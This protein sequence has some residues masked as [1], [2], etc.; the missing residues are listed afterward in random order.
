[1]FCHENKMTFTIYISDQEFE[2]SM[3]LL[4]VTDGNN[5]HYVYIKDVNRFMFRIQRIK[6]KNTFVEVVYSVS[7]VKMC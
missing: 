3:D 6:A 4:L 7:V 2:N 1:M 5:W